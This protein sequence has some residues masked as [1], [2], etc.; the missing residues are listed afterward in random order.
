MRVIFVSLAFGLLSV[1][2]FATQASATD[3]IVQL[4]GGTGHTCGIWEDGTLRC[5]GRNVDGQVG[6]GTTEPR[7]EPVEVA[8]IG[9]VEQVDAGLNHTCA[10]TVDA[11]AYCWG[12]NNIGQLGDGSEDDSP[13]PVGVCANPPACS[14][15]LSDVAQVAT[16]GS[17]SCALLNTGSVRCWGSNED[18]QLGT[19]DV[20][21]S[22]TAVTVET[23]TNVA[24]VSAG[25]SS[26][27]AL[28]EGGAVFCWGSNVE[29]QIGDDRACEMRCPLPQPVVGLDGGVEQI[30]AGGNHVCA[31]TTAGAVMCWGFNFDGQ[32]GDGTEDNIRIVPTQVNGLTSGIEAI[33]AGGGFRGHA[34]ALR[35]DGTL[36]C[37]GD[38]D[39]G[40]V[41]DGTM[42]D[43]LEPVAIPDLDG[44]IHMT[45]GDAFMCVITDDGAMFCWGTN[46]AGQFGDGTMDG[47]PSPIDT[48][49][50]GGGTSETGDANCDGIVNPVDA[51]FILQFSAGI[52]SSLPCDGD[53]NGNDLVDPVDAALVL[54]YSAGI[55]DEL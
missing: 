22:T 15:V 25:T 51:A 39:G 41:G 1:L 20:F 4:S 26:T 7:L 37:W 6:D 12:Q 8:N 19:D 54:Q 53:V 38:N 45:A 44:V 30:S 43:R 3:D 42:D 14:S 24:R 52:I 11:E 34:C 10:V 49:L 9:D 48:G 18:G 27:C 47:S 31:L 29:G 23:L 21:D 5:W 36:R 16:G 35:T 17:H 2:L 28:T 32:V 46:L 33:E 50:K 13:V 55:I 40:Q